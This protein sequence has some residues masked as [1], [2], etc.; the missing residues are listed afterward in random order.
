MDYYKIRG[1]SGGIGRGREMLWFAFMSVV[2][3]T[4]KSEQVPLISVWGFWIAMHRRAQ[5]L[6]DSETKKTSNSCWIQKAKVQWGSFWNNINSQGFANRKVFQL[7]RGNSTE[8]CLL[9]EWWKSE[10]RINLGWSGRKGENLEIRM[11]G[12][13]SD[14][15]GYSTTMVGN[16]KIWG[17]KLTPSSLH[18]ALQPLDV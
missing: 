11:K 9:G 18:A 17:L 6:K 13:D 5:A 1:L 12:R 3:Y 8:I 10:V 14:K 4:H 7:F 2:L 15:R 16:G